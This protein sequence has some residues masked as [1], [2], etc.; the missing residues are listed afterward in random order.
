MRY[1]T[2]SIKYGEHER[3]SETAETLLFQI[4]SY[5]NIEKILDILPSMSSINAVQFSADNYLDGIFLFT[6][7]FESVTVVV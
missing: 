1:Q 6:V 4:I 3:R 5:V 7:L 2:F